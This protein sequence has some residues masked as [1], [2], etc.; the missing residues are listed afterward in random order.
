MAKTPAPKSKA[1]PNPAGSGRASRRIKCACASCNCLVDMDRGLR[2][3]NL[4]YC[5]RAC[6][7][8]CS[9][10]VCACDHDCCHADD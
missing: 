8:E 10:E 9:F 2:K 5:S 4:L 6:L 1:A 7:T 3:G